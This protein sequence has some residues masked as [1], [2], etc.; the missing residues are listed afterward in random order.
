MKG[1]GRVK[2]C[3]QV[4][5]EALFVVAQS[6]NN[7]NVPQ[8]VNGWTNHRTSVR[9]VLVSNKEFRVPVWMNLEYVMLSERLQ[10]Q[11]SAYYIVP[12]LCHPGRSKTVGTET[13]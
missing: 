6:G 2:T 8:L 12:V 9:G 7:A 1:Y 11:E 4:F 3:T 10:P 13:D 5:V